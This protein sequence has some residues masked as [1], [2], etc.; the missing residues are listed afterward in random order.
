[1]FDPAN[2]P[3]K[4]PI[5][6]LGFARL[7]L[8]RAERTGD[9]EVIY[10]LGKTPEQIIRALGTLAEHHDRAVLATRVTPEAQAAIQR[11]LPQAR[12][13]PLARTATLGPLPSPRGLVVVLSAGTVDGPV[14]A[15]AMVSART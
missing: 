5:A 2:D 1:M 6:D 12:V 10:G 4:S 7:D 3:A 8:T 14:A 11:E 15:E 13:D 9:P